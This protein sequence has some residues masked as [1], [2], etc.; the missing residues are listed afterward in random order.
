[1]NVKEATGYLQQ[2]RDLR[3]FQRAQPPLTQRYRRISAG[4]L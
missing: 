2:L 3:T 4:E 1:M